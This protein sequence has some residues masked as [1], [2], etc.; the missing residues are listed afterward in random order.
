MKTYSQGTKTWKETMKDVVLTAYNPLE[1]AE[2][3]GSEST[4]VVVQHNAN[5]QSVTRG[6][7]S[8]KK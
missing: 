2:G 1:A 3:N 4:V 8:L 6:V 7:K 5:V